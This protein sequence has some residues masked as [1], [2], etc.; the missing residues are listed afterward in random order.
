MKSKPK[1][2]WQM[3]FSDNGYEFALNH[4]WKVSQ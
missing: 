2:A 1:Y 4:G 3:Y